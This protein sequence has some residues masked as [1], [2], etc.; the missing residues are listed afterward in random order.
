MSRCEEW[1]VCY[2]TTGAY[3]PKDVEALVSNDNEALSSNYTSGSPTSKKIRLINVAG[4]L[5]FSTGSRKE[6][7]KSKTETGSSGFKVADNS[8][9]IKSNIML[10]LR[11]AIEQFYEKIHRQYESNHISSEDID[12]E[13]LKICNRKE[14]LL[15]MGFV[16]LDDIL[17][18]CKKRS[19]TERR[20]IKIACLPEYP[21]DEEIRLFSHNFATTK[22]NIHNMLEKRISNDA[23][24]YRSDKGQLRLSTDIQ[25][26]MMKFIYE[27]AVF[28]PR[29]SGV[30]KIK[31]SEISN[32]ASR[33][34]LR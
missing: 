11:S 25:I 14:G 34:F 16:E 30:K 17:R 9:K 4:K 18:F 32:L 8:R 24:T 23:W 31:A 2:S 19:L 22:T 10:Q 26:S 29:K 3:R 15:R 13:I 12:D 28:A 6:E 20:L 27:N 1:A 33:I 21:T 7:S 5:S